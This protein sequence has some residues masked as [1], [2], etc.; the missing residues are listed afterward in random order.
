M[1]SNLQLHNCQNGGRL[2]LT[3]GN[4]F[5]LQSWSARHNTLL[6]ISSTSSQKTNLSPAIVCV[7]RAVCTALTPLEDLTFTISFSR[8][9]HITAW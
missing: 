7:F 1:V 6:L 8:L 5:S 4:A 9:P 2:R 3:K